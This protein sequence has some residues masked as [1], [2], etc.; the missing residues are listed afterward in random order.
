M[1]TLNGFRIYK[2][3]MI[4]ATNGKI[5]LAFKTFDELLNALFG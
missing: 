3:E 5:T 2:K 4:V 1:F